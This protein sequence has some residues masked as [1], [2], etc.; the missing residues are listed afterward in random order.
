MGKAINQIEIDPLKS[1]LSCHFV[2]LNRHLSTLAPFDRLLH[3]GIEILHAKADEVGIY[4]EIPSGL[5]SRIGTSCAQGISLQGGAFPHLSVHLV[6]RDL[7]VP[8]D[9]VLP[10][11]LQQNV[12]AE[13][14]GHD[15]AS[16]LHQRA[17]H[18][19]VS[20]EVDDGVNV[21]LSHHLVHLFCVANIPLL[22]GIA[23]I[24]CH[25]SQVIQIPG[26]GQLI[27][28]HDPIV[29]ILPQ[30]MMHE[31]AANEPSSASDKQVFQG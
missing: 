26:I 14:I 20:G 1:D 11:G 19:R 31:V 5:T 9:P 6:R 22:E 7:M 17:I 3:N 12:G 10:R 2:S 30:N 15:K 29:G 27:V 23:W 8:L 4:H 25:V 24:I 16:R 18:M 21:M 13:H 28:Y